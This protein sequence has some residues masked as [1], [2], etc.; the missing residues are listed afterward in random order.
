MNAFKNE[1][2]RRWENGV[3]TIEGYIGLFL[4]AAV[5][6]ACEHTDDTR[7]PVVRIA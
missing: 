6:W 1:N 5:S 3:E 2:T 4:I 7:P